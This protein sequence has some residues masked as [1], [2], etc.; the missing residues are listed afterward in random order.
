MATVTQTEMILELEEKLLPENERKTKLEIQR[1]YYDAAW[2]H[3]DNLKAMEDSRPKK[4]TR[5]KR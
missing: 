1:M 5:K 4:R 2:T 3:I